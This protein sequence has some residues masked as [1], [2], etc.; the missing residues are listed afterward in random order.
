MYPFACILPEF[1]GFLVYRIIQN[2]Y[3]QQCRALV[4]SMGPC[5]ACAEGL[6]T[7]GPYWGFT[8][9]TFGPRI[10]LGPL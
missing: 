6:P 2:L 5:R 8:G 10:Y 4:G 1:L 7:E 3:H 9:S